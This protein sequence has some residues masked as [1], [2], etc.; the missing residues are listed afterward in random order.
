MRTFALASGSSG[1][2]FY[3]ENDSEIKVLVDCG[4]SFQKIKEVLRGKGVN[5]E[6]LNAVFITHE[7]SDHCLGL[8]MMLKN[9]NCRFY[10]SSGTFEGLKYSGKD[11]EMALKKIELIKN[12]NV[13]NVGEI[14]VFCVDK[15]HDSLEAIS[16]VLESSGKK[17]G[18]FTDMGHVTDEIIHILKGLDI[19]YFEANYCKEYIGEN[20]KE[21]SWNYLSRLQSDIGHLGIHQCIEAMEKFV[22]DGQRIILSHIS[23]NTNFYENVYVKVSCALK[24]LGKS[25][26]IFVSYQG[27]ASE[28]IE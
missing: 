26:K 2:S 23:Q 16:Y 20:C 7:H 19:V 9:L 8:K 18:V 21:L 13:I 12:H 27:E 14:R 1:N 6:D 4:L 15:P 5:I 22:N 3:I 10:M 11:Y 24:D 17:L 28:W 25:P